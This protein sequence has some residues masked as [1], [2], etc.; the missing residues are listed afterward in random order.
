MSSFHPIS[1][2]SMSTSSC[3]VFILILTFNSFSF[4]SH[5]WMPI[6]TIK[7]FFYNNLTL[8]SFKNTKHT[9]SFR[10]IFSVC[11]V[12]LSFVFVLF[13]AL[14]FYFPSGEWCCQSKKKKL[15]KRQWRRD[16]LLP[17][18]LLW[19]DFNAYNKLVS[20]IEV[21]NMAVGWNNTMTAE[22]KITTV[23]KT[24]CLK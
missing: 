16:N 3:S 5:E 10:S 4:Y 6:N 20:F 15:N 24:W 19:I 21:L 11:Q 14:D 12:E 1:I 13:W 2:I 17:N 22:F 23:D 8:C 9:K 7:S 18:S